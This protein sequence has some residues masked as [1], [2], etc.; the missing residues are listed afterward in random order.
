MD[1]LSKK[2]DAQHFSAYHNYSDG[3]QK[4]VAHPTQFNLYNT[5]KKPCPQIVES[6][7]QQDDDVAVLSSPG[8]QAELLSFEADLSSLKVGISLNE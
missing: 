3:G 6:Y 4:S 2:A 8:Q 7:Q 5:N 1:Y